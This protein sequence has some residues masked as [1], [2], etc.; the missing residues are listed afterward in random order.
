MSLI[1][2]GTDFLNFHS[3]VKFV[4]G[5]YIFVLAVI[6]TYVAI[7]AVRLGR[8]QRELAELRRLV[9]EREAEQ[10][11]TGAGQATPG[12]EQVVAAR[13]AD[14]EAVRSEHQL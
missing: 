12:A 6:F 1:A 7:M 13:E 2:T 5:A 11:I 3:S 14:A 10:A 4:A 8:N 9:D